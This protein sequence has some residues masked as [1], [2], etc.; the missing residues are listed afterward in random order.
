LYEIV[1]AYK[2]HSN[3]ASNSYM[4]LL[5][6]KFELMKNIDLYNT[7]YSITILYSHVEEKMK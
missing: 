3:Y 2:S 4:H 5:N 7:M 6:M 1:V